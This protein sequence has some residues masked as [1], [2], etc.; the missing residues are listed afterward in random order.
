MSEGAPRRILIA[1]AGVN[2]IGIIQQ[3]RAMG[4]HTIA[5][6]GSPQAAGFAYA[7]ESVVVDISDG[8]ALARV[9]QGHRVD[10]LYPAAEFAVQACAQ[11]ATQCRLPG[12]TPEVAL[13]V[14]NK[15]A[16]REALG[17]QFSPPYARVTNVDEA[18]AEAARIGY[19]V[20]VKPVDGN[21]SRGVRCVH[22]EE[23]L[24]TAFMAAAN[25]SA[26]G[27]VLLEGYVEGE[28]Y[29]VEGVVFNG[30]FTPGAVTGKLRSEPPYHYDRGIY[31][32]AFED[33]I[34]EQAVFDV[35]AA[36]LDAVGF[37]NGTAHVEVI[38]SDQ[39]SIIVEI[40]GRPG[41]GRI[42]SDLIPL[43]HGMD[44][45]GDSLRVALGEAPKSTRRFRRGSAL[46]WI[47]A[48]PGRVIE[49]CGVEA[50]RALPGVH[51]VHIAAKIG[52]VLDAVV[53]CSSRDAIGYVIASGLTVAEAL[54]AAERGRMC[55]RIVTEPARTQ[56]GSRSAKG[57]V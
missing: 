24:D 43:A 33:E 4:L 10:G 27:A 29:N 19:P 51:D 57:G 30:R 16:M 15:F 54:A 31:T 2:Q 17:G 5:A 48:P 50:A 26:S 55:C 35:V 49:M 39:G 8:E 28:E 6:D 32:P 36:A 37:S 12:V 11:A 1:G 53:D 45:V 52:M 38:L 47:T 7:D 34:V 14:R 40:A 46:L 56:A 42:P 9:S 44:F 3:A 22:T 21:A 25:A 23:E 20:M 13:R 18:Y 41:G